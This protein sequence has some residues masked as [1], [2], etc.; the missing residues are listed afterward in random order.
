MN[1]NEYLFPNR[2]NRRDFLKM[3]G[4]ASAG[5]MLPGVGRAKEEAASAPVRIGSGYHTYEA[6]QDWG[7]LP[8]GMKYGFGCGVVVD[9]KDQVYVTS[10]STSPCVAIFDRDGNLIETWSKEF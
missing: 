7:K 3:A 4:A 1:T 9:S 5:L 2:L 6:V 8:D 10:R